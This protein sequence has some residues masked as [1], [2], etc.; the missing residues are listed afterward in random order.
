MLLRVPEHEVRDL[1]SWELLERTD[2][3]HAS[4]AGYTRK[5]V[6]AVDALTAFVSGGACYAGVS[7]GKDSTV[8]ARLIADHAPHVPL[9]WIRV[10]P[11]KNPHC[12]LVR[13]DFLR[14][15]RVDYHEI[16]VWCRRDDAGW[17]ASGTLERGYALAAGRWGRRHISGVRGAESGSRK[18]RMRRWG[19]ATELTCA[20]IGWWSAADVYAYLAEHGLPVHP[21]YA[22]SQGGLWDRDRIRVASLGGRRGD[23]TGRAEWERRYYADAI[24]RINTLETAG[25]AE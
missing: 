10:E 16:E 5:V 20:P 21:A 8:L 15:H 19:E 2:R 24:R 25:L 17:H 7:W 13:D 4:L 22:M 1:E 11:I 9:V 6:R 3:I 18:M 14:A 12:E 23:G